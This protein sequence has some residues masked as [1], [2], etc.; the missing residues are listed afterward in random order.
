MVLVSCEKAIPIFTMDF[1]SI[2]YNTPFV[3]YFK[4]WK[5]IAKF[6]EH[7]KKS[8]IFVP[9]FSWNIMNK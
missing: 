8:L 1:L 5:K 4:I 7:C 2:W 6:I 9:S 3:I